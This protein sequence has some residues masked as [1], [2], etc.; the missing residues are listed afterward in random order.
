MS[1]QSP[2]ETLGEYYERIYCDNSA[3]RGRGVNITPKCYDGGREYECTVY[4]NKY[5]IERT[6]PTMVL[7]SECRK[8]LRKDCRKRKYRFKSKKVK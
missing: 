4:Y 6:G 2:Y 5:G 7:C 3:K 1:T 8:N